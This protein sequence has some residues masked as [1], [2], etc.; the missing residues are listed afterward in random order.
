MSGGGGLSGGAVIPD[1]MC[2]VQG[3][4]WGS[5]VRSS[6]DFRQVL[7]GGGSMS[8]GGI[9]SG[10]GVLSGAVVIPAMMCPVQGGCPVTGLVRR[11]GD[12]RGGTLSGEGQCPV[13]VVCPVEVLRFNCFHRFL[14][15]SGVIRKLHLEA[16]G[17]YM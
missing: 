10:G 2:P 4:V 16:D 13:E 6:W 15:V 5:V 14:L 3:P 11:S 12:V 8:G 7:S 9:L 1:M 17:R